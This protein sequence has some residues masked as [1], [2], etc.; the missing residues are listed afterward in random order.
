M[1]DNTVQLVPFE[2]IAAQDAVAVLEQ[3]L[4]KAKA[5]ELVGVAIAAVRYDGATS[6]GYSKCAN[7]GT[8]IGAIARLQHRV[9]EA[10]E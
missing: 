10:H 6:T 8:L 1:T 9:I 4:A 5:G 7:V 3:W 2:R